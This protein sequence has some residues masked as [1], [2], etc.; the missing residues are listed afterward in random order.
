MARGIRLLRVHGLRYVG[1]LAPSFTPLGIA[2]GGAFFISYRGSVISYE[3]PKFSKKLEFSYIAQK[4]QTIYLLEL[5]SSDGS[6]IIFR[7]RTSNTYV[8]YHVKR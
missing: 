5:N 8:F 6:D 3:Y 4:A 1:L 7:T 2:P